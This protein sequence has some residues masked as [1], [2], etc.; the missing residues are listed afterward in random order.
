MGPIIQDP[1]QVADRIA[2]EGNATYVDVRPVAAFV[3]GHPRGRV[4]NVPYVFYHP[5]T[6]A[7]HAN[8]SFLLVLQHAC[9]LT[10]PLIVGGDADELPEHAAA[11]LVAAGY[12]ELAIMPAGLGGWRACG[13]SVTGNNRD[14][15]SYVSLLTPAKRQ[16]KQ[17]PA[18]HHD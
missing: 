11:E 14:G 5:V 9:P 1:L 18:A 13:L 16:G 17:A 6:G 3:K 15:V 4:I 12:A 8:A 2:A 7:R 10:T